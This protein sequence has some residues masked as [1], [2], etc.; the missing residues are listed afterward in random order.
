MY[1]EII[2]KL[3]IYIYKDDIYK[4]FFQLVLLYKNLN[5]SYLIFNFKS[6]DVTSIM[7]IIWSLSLDTYMDISIYRT[8][9]KKKLEHLNYIFKHRYKQMMSWL[10]PFKYCIF[11]RFSQILSQF[12]VNA[13]PYF[14]ILFPGTW[15]TIYLPN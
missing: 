8:E 4:I 2:L 6:T 7:M 3:Y 1:I 9:K 15:G 14:A 5:N 12:V 13:W 11:L 10:S